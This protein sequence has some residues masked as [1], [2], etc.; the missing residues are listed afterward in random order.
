MAMSSGHMVLG[1]IIALSFPGNAVLLS[2]S[3]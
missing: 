1:N 3:C 2:V